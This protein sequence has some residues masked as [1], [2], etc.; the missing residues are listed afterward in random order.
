MAWKPFVP[1]HC[2]SIVSIFVWYWRKWSTFISTPQSQHKWIDFVTIQ[3]RLG[4]G[5]SIYNVFSHQLMWH[6]CFELLCITSQFFSNWLL[7]N[8]QLL[9][10]S[11]DRQTSCFSLSLCWG[12]SLT[13]DQVLVLVSCNFVKNPHF[14]NSHIYIYIYNWLCSH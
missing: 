11:H 14:S 7:R 12:P 3:Q 2:T 4:E 9:M 8:I 5:N 6:S 10:S 1:A 13:Y